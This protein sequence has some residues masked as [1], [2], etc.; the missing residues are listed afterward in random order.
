[1]HLPHG[2]LLRLTLRSLWIGAEKVVE[3]E[4]HRRTFGCGGDKIFEFAEGVR[5]D[6]V[7]FVGSEIP[8]HFAFVGINIEMVEPEIIHD[9]LQLALAVD[10]AGYFSHGQFFDNALGP[11]AVVGDG[12]RY[13]IGINAK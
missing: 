4:Q 5:L 7:S 8:L 2:A 9:L 11:L 6:D 10:G 1:M 13:G 3:V 12:A